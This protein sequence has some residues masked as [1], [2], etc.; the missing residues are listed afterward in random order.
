MSDRDDVIESA[1][2]FRDAAKDC[3]VELG[4]DFIVTA[5]IEQ[6]EFLREYIATLHELLATPAQEAHGKHEAVN[7]T[8]ED[9]PVLP[10]KRGPGRPRK[11]QD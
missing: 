1:Q 10:V 11:A 5:T 3:V 8:R 2:H 4:V 7:V 6:A 9:E